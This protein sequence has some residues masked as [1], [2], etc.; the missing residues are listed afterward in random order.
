LTTAADWATKNALNLFDFFRPS[1]NADN[2][3]SHAAAFYRGG[4]A[5]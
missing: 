3:T 1:F 5:D 2:E 4:S